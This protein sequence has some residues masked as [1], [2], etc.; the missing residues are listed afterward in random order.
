ME[1]SVKLIKERVEM[2]GGYLEVDSL[3]VRAAHYLPD[4]IG[5]FCI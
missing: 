2:L 5:N 3:L 1:L 4:T